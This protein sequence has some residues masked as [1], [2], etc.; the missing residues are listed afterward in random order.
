MFLD[1]PE[2]SNVGELHV[3]IVEERVNFLQPM[4]VQFGLI[5]LGVR[6][7]I[8]LAK[9]LIVPYACTRRSFLDFLSKFP[10]IEL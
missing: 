5:Y 6:P 3:L 10:F 7:D 4:L 2:N 8:D 9:Q 1:L